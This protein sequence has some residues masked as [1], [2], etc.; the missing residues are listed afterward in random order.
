MV[1]R[2]T[3]IPHQ[4]NYITSN[5]TTIKPRYTTPLHLSHSFTPPYSLPLA[6]ATSPQ[7]SP[8]IPRE[9]Y[10]FQASS[11]VKLITGASQCTKHRKSRF[12]TYKHVLRF[13]DDAP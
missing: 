8:R 3:H 4:N 12:I 10:S 7:A 2:T 11:D 1:Y 9:Q 5:N 6:A 13:D